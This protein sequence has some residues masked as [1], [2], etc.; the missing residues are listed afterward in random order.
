M[1]IGRTENANANNAKKCRK[2]IQLTRENGVRRQ[3]RPFKFFR[4]N[5]FFP[6]HRMKE[7]LPGKRQ[8]M[9]TNAHKCN[10]Q[11]K[12]P[13]R[14]KCKKMQ[15]HSKK[16]KNNGFAYLVPPSAWA[17]LGYGQGEKSSSKNVQQSFANI[18]V[19]GCHCITAPKH[20]TLAALSRAMER[21]RK[22][23]KVAR[24]LKLQ[25]STR[26]LHR[27]MLAVHMHIF[28]WCLFAIMFLPL[29]FS[30]L[31]LCQSALTQRS[32]GSDRNTAERNEKKVGPTKR[33][34]EKNA[35]HF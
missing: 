9:P 22:K 35:V 2:K 26:Y 3:T 12:S 34:E 23:G 8:Q 33:S 32:F 15:Q 17:S 21:G 14:K 11:G 20:C 19:H 4:L 31:D 6:R 5:P 28:S 27:C 1:Q 7:I 18:S 30:P 13:F 10:L 29:Q 25:I 16:C 24:C